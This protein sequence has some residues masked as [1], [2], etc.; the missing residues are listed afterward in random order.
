MEACGQVQKGPLELKGVAELSMTKQ[1]EKKE[2]DKAKR[3]EAMGMSIKSKEQRCGLEKWASAQVALEEM[4]QM[5]RI[6]KKAS[7]THI[8]SEHRGLSRDLDTLLE[9]YDTPGVSWA[10]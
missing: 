6:L 2:K 7:K 1:K 9:H 8:P 5:E 10:K 4:Q 3:L